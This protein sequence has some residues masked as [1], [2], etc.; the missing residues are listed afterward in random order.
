M[1]DKHIVV[2]FACFLA[3]VVGG[4][5]AAEES[6][7]T[8]SQTPAYTVTPT[9]NAAQLLVTVP[10]GITLTPETTIVARR[11][12]NPEVTL[13][14]GEAHAVTA[15]E[16]CLTTRVGSFV[17]HP[18]CNVP[19]TNGQQTKVAFGAVTF[20]IT[21]GE[22]VL[23]ADA[24]NEGVFFYANANPDIQPL[25][26]PKALAHPAGTFTYYFGP[27]HLKVTVEE[28]K[29]T[30]DMFD[31]PAT[32]GL[33]RLLPPATRDFPDAPEAMGFTVYAGDWVSNGIVRLDTPV[34][35]RASSAQFRTYAGFQSV[36]VPLAAPGQPAAPVQLGRID[37]DDV[38]V[39]MPDGTVAQVPGTFTVSSA[40]LGNLCNACA[41]KHGVDAPP[42][43]Y[44]ISVKY[45]HP[46]DGSVATYEETVN[47]P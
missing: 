34:V 14:P 8:E 44:Q 39:T 4:C 1:S 40:G 23:G 46:G 13:V 20:D 11:G 32:S 37:V 7:D 27:D 29:L 10:D 19:V 26:L 45:I 6:D 2:G 5:T 12:S 3:G 24:R 17:S 21:P 31:K 43:A 25:A 9:G 42:G 22:R 41:T 30:T 35:V 16:Y 28:G 38:A 36:P 33:A 15:G 18:V 47:L